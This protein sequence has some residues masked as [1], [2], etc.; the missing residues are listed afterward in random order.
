MKYHKSC[1]R[2]SIFNQ[3]S[4]TQWRKFKY[5]SHDRIFNIYQISFTLKHIIQLLLNIIY[6]KTENST[7]TEYQKQNNLSNPDSEDLSIPSC[8]PDSL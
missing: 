2:I 1:N 8:N 7:S 6:I 3:K 5:S 4:F